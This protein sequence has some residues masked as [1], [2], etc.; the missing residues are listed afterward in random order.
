MY[1]EYVVEDEFGF[2]VAL[3]T[4]EIVNVHIVRL[5]SSLYLSLVT[6]FSFF[7]YFWV[8]VYNSMLGYAFSSLP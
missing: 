8:F 2:V 5:T 3:L 7:G 4:T 1:V 6:Y